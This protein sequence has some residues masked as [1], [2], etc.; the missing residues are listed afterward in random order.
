MIRMVTMTAGLE[1]NEISTGDVEDELRQCFFREKNKKGSLEFSPM[2]E[3]DGKGSHHIDFLLSKAMYVV[4]R[5]LVHDVK[6]KAAQHGAEL[7]YAYLTQK[8]FCAQLK[9]FKFF[10]DRPKLGDEEVVSTN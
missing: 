3:L 4:V 9:Q 8:G 10:N 6:Q 5:R 1:N 7:T 2:L